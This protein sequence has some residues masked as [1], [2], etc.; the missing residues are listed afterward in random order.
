[1]I[2]TKHKKNGNDLGTDLCVWVDVGGDG[3]V[4][5]VDLVR[6]QEEQRK[7]VHDDDPG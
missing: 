5:E 6:L 1:M 3:K 7:A 2:A 4:L